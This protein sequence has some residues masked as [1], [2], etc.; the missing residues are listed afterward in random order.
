MWLSHEKVCIPHKIKEQKDLRS[1]VIEGKYFV[2]RTRETKLCAVTGTPSRPYLLPRA[3]AR[4]R[5][6]WKPRA[7]T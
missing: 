4:Q 7:P 3:A 2:V 1:L 6:W 5:A